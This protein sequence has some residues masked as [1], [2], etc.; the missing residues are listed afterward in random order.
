MEPDTTNLRDSQR[1]VEKNP[2]RAICT[3]IRSKRKA[4]ELKKRQLV[5]L[6]AH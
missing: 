1:K 2:A 4:W 3:S 6:H 5:H